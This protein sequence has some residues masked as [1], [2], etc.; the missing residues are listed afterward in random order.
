MSKTRLR[1]LLKQ[2]REELADADSVG[3]EAH[4]RLQSVMND[5]DGLLER[6]G[7]DSP[8]EETSINDRLNQA[9]VEFETDH[10][11]VGFTIQRLMQSLTDIGI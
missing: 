6:T 5:I 9:L 4:D 11:Q 7:S 2:L 10:P 3:S 1:Y 8:D